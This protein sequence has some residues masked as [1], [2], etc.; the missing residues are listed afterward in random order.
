MMYLSSSS[1]TGIRFL[2]LIKQGNGLKPSARAA[3]INKEVGDRW[4][5]ERYLRFRSEAM[6][7]AEATDVLRF[8]TSRLPIRE[9]AV[10]VATGRHHLQ[11]NVEDETKFWTAFDGG[12]GGSGG[13]GRRSEPL[14]GVPVDQL[15]IR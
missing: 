8:T 11:W 12:S 9:A 4:L 10:G 2:A 6:S 1:P 7:P 3:G 15:P 5:R 13:R 14:H